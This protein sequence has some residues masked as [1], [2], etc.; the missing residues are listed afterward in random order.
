MIVQVL[1]ETGAKTEPRNPAH[2]I[3]EIMVLVM[4]LNPLFWM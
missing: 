2:I 1:Y 3:L 4:V